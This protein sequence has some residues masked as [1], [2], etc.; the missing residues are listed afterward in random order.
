M[1]T[2]KLLQIIHFYRDKFAEL[3]VSK[4]KL[5]REDKLAL[6]DMEWLQHCCAILDEIEQ[7]VKQGNRQRAYGWIC[8]IQGMLCRMEIYT[9]EDVQNHN[10][11][12]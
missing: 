9:L 1:T 2:Q 10:R 5:E 3:G 11:P 8:F 7:F 4:K 12:V 6:E